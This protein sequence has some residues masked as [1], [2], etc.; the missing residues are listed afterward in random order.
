M[1]LNRASSRLSRSV[2]RVWAFIGMIAV[3]P[4]ACA[5]PAADVGF[6]RLAMG[7]YQ[8]FVVNWDQR[9]SPFLCALIGSQKRWTTVMHRA[10]TMKKGK[11]F[12]PEAALFDSNDI[13]LVSRIV[14][15]EGDFSHA[16]EIKE[17]H[18][19]GRDMQVAVAVAA[20][21]AA[22]FSVKAYSMVEIPKAKGGAFVVVVDGKTVCRV[23][24]GADWVQPP[25]AGREK[26]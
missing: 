26:P 14:P 18:S 20:R 9:D 1:K 16:V 2:L 23:A 3:A 6:K 15:G 21:P 8:A 19:D 5:D 7:A 17:I 4:R 24:P 22:S 10:P 12:A 25:S 13:L 11:P